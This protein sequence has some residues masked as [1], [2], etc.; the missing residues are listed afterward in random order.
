[1]KPK[2]NHPLYVIKQMITLLKQMIFP[3]IVVFFTNLK[4]QKTIIVIL[5]IA[6]LLAVIGIF[7]FLSWQ[8]TYYYV[9]KD[10]LFYEKGILN[11][12]KQ[13]IGLD[14]ITTINENQ[15]L[16]ERI[17]QLTTFK[18]DAG[19]AT[20]GNEIKL[21]ISRKEAQLLKN[22]LSHHGIDESI[23]AATL[24]MNEMSKVEETSIEFHINVKELVIYAIMSNSFFAGLAFVL[25]IWQFGQD[26][27]FVKNLMDGPVANQINQYFNNNVKGLSITSLIA[28]V[29]IAVFAYLF[30]S[31]IISIVL[32]VVKYFDFTVKR[33]GESIEISYG[34]LDRKNYNLSVHKITALYLNYGLI[35]QLYKIGTLKI[36]SIGYGDEKGEAAILYPLLKN[37]KRVEILNALLPEYAF[38]ESCLRPPK[39]A[40]KSY[41]IKY[42]TLPMIIAAV[43]TF[44]VPYGEAAWVFVLILG[45]SSIMSYKKTSI[46]R[47]KNQFVMMG[48]IFGKW[49]AV[50]KKPH[51]QAIITKQSYFQKRAKLVHLEYSYQSNNFGKKLG[52]QFMDEDEVANLMEF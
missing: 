32:A 37:Q 8:N 46:S 4:G 17:F 31:L 16:I 49:V 35:G 15:E 26:I 19:S 25:A 42:M 10:V 51:I 28:M 21:T 13:G 14:K 48:G 29:L 40:L 27:P 12:S 2:H 34:L 47:T 52:V 5:G 6:V 44:V 33:K 7:A 50:I 39:R 11:K 41:L 18:V 9:E 36:E 20:K 24:E 1:M 45:L 43:L 22:A 38:D 3:I 23:Q 30:F